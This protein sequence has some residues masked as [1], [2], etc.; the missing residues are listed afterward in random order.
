MSNLIIRTAKESDFIDISKLAKKCSPMAT[1]RDSIYHIFTKFFQNT[2]FVIERNDKKMIGFLLGFI[3]Q[4]DS[5]EAYIHLL[6]VDPFYRKKGL[7]MD[8][9]NKFFNVVGDKGCKRVSLI[10]KP[11]NQNAIEFYEKLGFKRSNNIKTVNLGGIL[12]IKD[13]NGFGN[14][15][16][17]FEKNISLK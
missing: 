12:A 16:V 5:E 2:V 3:S 1:E 17:V 8:L 7:A 14:H 10:T 15:M 9:L 11:I 4:V 13:Y 6:C